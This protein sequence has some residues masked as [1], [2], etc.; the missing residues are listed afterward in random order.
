M[1][2]SKPEVTLLGEATRMI[3]SP[4]PSKIAPVSEPNNRLTVN[5]AYD[6]DE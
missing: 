6:L 1:I 3:E 2:Y 5:P 4:P